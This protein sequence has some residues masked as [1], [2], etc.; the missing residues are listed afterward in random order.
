MDAL[1]FQTVSCATVIGVVA[2]VQGQLVEKCLDRGDLI[3][4]VR[5]IFSLSSGIA[6]LFLVIYF[7][8]FFIEHTLLSTFCLGALVWLL[9]SFFGAL[10]RYSLF[11]GFGGCVAWPVS[12]FLLVN[13]LLN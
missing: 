11:V 1:T 4:S 8:W 10:F 2:F 5:D 13:D 6:V 12:A 3:R 7:I 9:N